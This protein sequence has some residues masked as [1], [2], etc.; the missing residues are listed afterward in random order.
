MR[1]WRHAA[2]RKTGVR[3]RLICR[4]P[5]DRFRA[6]HILEAFDAHS[7]VAGAEHDDGPAVGDEDE[8]LHD[9]LDLG[10]D[11]PGRVFGGPRRRGEAADLDGRAA[12][13]RIGLDPRDV[14][15]L[16]VQ[17]Q[18]CVKKRRTRPGRSVSI[19]DAA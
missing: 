12:L 7:L 18:R 9:A 8:G 19:A 14:R 4:C 16:G 13:G 1:E 5:A 11:L 10:A 17:R 15:V 3:L 6:K 2:D